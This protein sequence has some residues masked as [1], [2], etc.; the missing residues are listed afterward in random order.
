MESYKERIVYAFIRISRM[1]IGNKNYEIPRNPN[2]AAWYASVL[3]L[4][5]QT[6]RSIPAPNL[7]AI[8]VI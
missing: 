6:R 1:A 5:R 4:L 8:T 2:T 3:R 7:Q